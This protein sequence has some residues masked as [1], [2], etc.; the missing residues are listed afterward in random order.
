VEA[1]SSFQMFVLICHATRCYNPDVSNIKNVI[2]LVVSLILGHSQVKNGNFSCYSC[3]CGCVIV[4][5]VVS[6][7]S[8]VSVEY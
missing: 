2:G 3:M 4:K 6:D 8:R 7:F 1:G 5:T